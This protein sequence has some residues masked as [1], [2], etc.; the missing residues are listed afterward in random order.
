MLGNTKTRTMDIQA[1]SQTLAVVSAITWVALVLA[2]GA[3]SLLV[4]LGRL[5][6]SELHDISERSGA[7][8]A[9][10]FIPPSSLL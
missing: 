6:I 2:A 5:G 1:H 7:A 9:R 10:Y 3:G 4:I 8:K